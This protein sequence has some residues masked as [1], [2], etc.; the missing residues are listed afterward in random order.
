ME[1]DTEKIKEGIAEAIQ[2]VESGYIAESFLLKQFLLKNGITCQIQI[3]VTTQE[4][5]FIEN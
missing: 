1:I 5:D 4:F 3:V 2:G